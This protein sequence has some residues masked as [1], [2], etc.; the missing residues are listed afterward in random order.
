MYR[1]KA[2]YRRYIPNFGLGY[3]IKRFDEPDLDSALNR[4]RME[5]T[6]EYIKE[7]SIED[8]NRVVKN[9]REYPI[10]EDYRK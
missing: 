8:S 6:D 10:Q 2:I 5:M 7:V 9:V 4:V 3:D 1:V